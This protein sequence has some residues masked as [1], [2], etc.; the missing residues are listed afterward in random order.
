MSVTVNSNF[1]GTNIA[2][3]LSLIVLGAETIQKGLLH[4]IPNKYDVIY[5]PKL[6]TAP[7]QLQ[8]RVPTPTTSATSDYTERTISPKD[9]MWYQEFNPATFEHVWQDFWPRGPMVNQVQDPKIMAAIVKTVRGSI[10]T[11]LDNLIWQGDEG[12]AVPEL[13]FFD[14]FLKTMTADADVIKY[15]IAAE[16][17]K[18]N[19][20]DILSGMI[21][22]MPP[23]IRN[24]RRPKFIVSHKTFDAFGEYTVNVDYKGNDLFDPTTPRYR[25]YDII[26]VGGMTDNQI[27]FAEATTGPDGNLFAG[28]WLANDRENF[29][30]ERLQANSEMFFLKSLFRYGVNYGKG[31]EIVLGTY[32]AP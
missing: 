13:A 16:I 23:A 19:I 18:G 3:I 2:N 31:Q 27:V 29:K 28:T 9:M 5:M 11:Q 26:P 17:S 20:K 15:P 24:N 12:G 25:G 6:D 4:T 22:A 30:I 1:V 7:N 21:S 14:G 32:T 8:A 10:N